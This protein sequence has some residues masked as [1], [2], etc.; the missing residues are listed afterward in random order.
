MN[1]TSQQIGHG[2]TLS[3][4]LWNKKTIQSQ[5]RKQI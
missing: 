3:G 1:S 2:Y 5:V 4:T